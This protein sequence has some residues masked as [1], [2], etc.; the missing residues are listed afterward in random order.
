MRHHDAPNWPP[1][2]RQWRIDGVK[3]MNGEVGVLIYVYAAGDSRKCYLVIE[4]ENENYTG[5]LLL[6]TQDISPSC[7]TF[8]TPSR[9]INQRDWRLGRES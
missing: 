8:A 2:W 9:S 7:E 1:V 4:H 5:T 6:M 3:E